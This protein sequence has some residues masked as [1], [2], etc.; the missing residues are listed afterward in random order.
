M[1]DYN[2]Y[3]RNKKT[4]DKLHTWSL[5]HL[6]DCLNLVAKEISQLPSDAHPHLVEF[7]ECAKKEFEKHVK[8]KQQK[9]TE[10]VG[11]ESF[12]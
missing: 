6:I 1:E 8:S 10:N 3:E 4:I 12:L 9:I 11:H 2:F 7:L 5:L